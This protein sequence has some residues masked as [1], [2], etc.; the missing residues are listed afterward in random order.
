[1]TTKTD[2]LS[3]TLRDVLTS[4]NVSDSN[5]EAANL[6]DALGNLASAMWFGVDHRTDPR[7]RPNAMEFHAEAILE[8]AGKIE[9]GLAF[10]ASA[11]GDL[12]TAV[13]ERAR[14]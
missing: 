10:V 3:E 7:K 11:I 6:V 4:P 9:N 13:R 14:E 8:A 2:Q 1:M 12:A 5:G